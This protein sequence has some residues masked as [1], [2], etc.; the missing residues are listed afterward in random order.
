M[1]RS[2]AR[3][4][5]RWEEFSGRMNQVPF[6]PRWGLL[7]FEHTQF[8][9]LQRPV[10]GQVGI[11]Q[12]GQFQVGRLASLENGVGDIRTQEGQREKAANIALGVPCTGPA[13]FRVVFPGRYPFNYRRLLYPPKT[14]TRKSFGGLY[15][16]SES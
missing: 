7:F 12:I 13:N 15:W 1:L 3:L 4:M 2:Q 9:A 16:S 8:L 10:R 14:N 5:A 6:G 11:K